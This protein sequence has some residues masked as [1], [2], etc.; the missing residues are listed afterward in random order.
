MK[1]TGIH[2]LDPLCQ[3]TAA[4]QGQA[5]NAVDGAFDRIA[6]SFSQLAINATTWLWQQIHDATTLDLHDPK[7]LHETATT[8]VIAGVLCLA[9][10][11]IQVTMSVLR[12]EPG[13]LG[14]ALAGLVISFVGCAFALVATRTL[15]GVVD[16]ISAGYVE[17]ALGTNIEGLGRKFAFAQM[18]TIQSPAAAL[19]LSLVVLVAVVMVWAAMMIRKL[20][21]IIA[22][23]L[24]PL[25]FAGAT[26]DITRS[27]VRRWV[28]F[29]AAMIVSKLLLV[30]ILSIGLAVFEGA[31]QAGSGAGQ[32]ATQLAAGSL[33]LLMGGFTPWMAIKMFHFAGDTFHA[34]HLTVGQSASGGRAVIAAPQKVGALAWTATSITGAASRLGGS[35]A[36]GQ[37]TQRSTGVRSAGQGSSNPAPP[38]YQFPRRP[39]QPPTHTELPS[40]PPNKPINPPPHRP[41]G[42]K[43]D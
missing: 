18:T 39:E 36:A 32:V 25:A 11:V 22:A 40:K 16:L 3:A 42:Q 26:A 6:R 9:L 1:C 41:G 23:V 13:G 17:H 33:I 19:L 4:I 37:L 10:F 2:A 30:I 31:G 29:V 7:L 34:A 43:N 24:A 20:L 28:E 14:R 8:A 27:W 38:K 35:A 21:L 15:L 12:H 5:A